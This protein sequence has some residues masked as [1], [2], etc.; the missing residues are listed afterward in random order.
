[1]MKWLLMPM[2]LAIVPTVAVADKG[3]HLHHP[4]TGVSLNNSV[5]QRSERLS[6]A[7]FV[8]NHAGEALDASVPMFR[9]L[10]TARL[11]EKGF[12]IMD[13]HDVAERFQE[14]QGSP[15]PVVDVLRAVSKGIETAKTETSVE[16]VLNGASA[17]RIAQM[18][19]A[20][21][22]V[23]ATFASVGGDVKTFHGEGTLYKSGNEVVTRTLR[24]SLKVLEGNK[25]STVYGDTVVSKARYGGNRHLTTENDDGDNALIDEAANTIADNISAKIQRIK[26][27][28]VEPQ[29]T[30]NVE[31]ASN[32]PGATLE[33]DG[34]TLGSLPGVFSIRPGIHQVAVSKERYVTWRRTVNV[35]PNQVLTVTLERS[36]VGDDRNENSLRVA[37]EDEL[38]RKT[39]EANIDI[40]KEQ[41][42]A[43]A[44]AKRQV[45]DGEKEYRKNSHTQIEGPVNELNIGRSA[46]ALVKVERE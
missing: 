21:Y 1:M 15:D 35:V 17:L 28:V 12:A 10:L 13:G 6:A 24:T 29:S 8:Q 32:V 30:H 16:S 11:T 18:L 3:D 41:S 4:V 23:V 33:V 31:V 25:G 46:D 22:L 7:I 27:T 44:Y 9:D 14:T 2:V 40:A 5:P 43:D 38:I 45:A 36:A 26:D 19:D 34:A 39:E 37:R 42:S 20:D